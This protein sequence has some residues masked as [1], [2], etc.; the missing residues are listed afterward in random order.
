MGE[1][2]ERQQ[3]LQRKLR[4]QRKE[5]LVRSRSEMGE[6]ALCGDEHAAKLL[7]KA[8]NKKLKPAK[9]PTL[10][11][12]ATT[13]FM[14]MGMEMGAVGGSS[15]MKHRSKCVEK[16]KIAESRSKTGGKGGSK[17]AVVFERVKKRKRDGHQ[18]ADHGIFKKRRMQ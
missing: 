6:V 18:Q 9:K 14:G 15:F 17:K 7:E 3:R 2:E 1:R 8:K 16:A 5:F 12:A 10:G 13:A 11:K 4:V